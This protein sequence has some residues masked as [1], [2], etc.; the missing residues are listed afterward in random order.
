LIQKQQNFKSAICKQI[1][2]V[3]EIMLLLPSLPT[4][5]A[6]KVKI[7]DE[8]ENSSIT[9]THL[10][11]IFEPPTPNCN[12]SFNVTLYLYIYNRVVL[13]LSSLPRTS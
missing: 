1:A 12:E 3:Y 7:D 10:I 5:K 4:P 8:F 6:H 13:S 9:K 11:S 2:N